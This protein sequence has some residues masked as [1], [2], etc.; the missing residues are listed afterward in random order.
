MK[1]FTCTHMEKCTYNVLVQIRLSTSIPYRLGLY[2]YKERKYKC[3]T[4]S[5]PKVYYYIEY[6]II[7]QLFLVSRKSINSSLSTLQR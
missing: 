6:A 4:N 7:V 2:L 3:D 5:T 1:F